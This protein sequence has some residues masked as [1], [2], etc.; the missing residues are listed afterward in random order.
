[1]LEDRAFLIDGMPREDAWE[2]EWAW[3]PNMVQWS[4][5]QLMP[6]NFTF[7]RR[8]AALCGHL[9]PSS[10]AK[11]GTN[12]GKIWLLF[13]NTQYKR[14]LHDMGL[15]PE[16]AMGCALSIMF[17]PAPEALQPVQDILRVMVNPDVL[18]I[19]IHIRTGEREAWGK[20]PR[21]ACLPGGPRGNTDGPC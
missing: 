13:H 16:T 8:M 21:V 12:K 5:K 2:F 9:D 14:R 11:S 19:G 7:E 6:A 3:R 15:R 18:K 10:C 20:Q 17:N 4:L 1:M